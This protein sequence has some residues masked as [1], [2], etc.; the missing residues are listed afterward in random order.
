MSNTM[1]QPVAWALFAPN[2]NIR[3][4]SIN[5]EAVHKVAADEGW[6]LTPLYAAPPTADFEFSH[7]AMDDLCKRMIELGRQQVAEP[8]ASAW[9]ALAMGAAASIEDAANCLHDHDAR[10]QAEGAAKHYREAAHKLIGPSGVT[11]C[12][13][14]AVTRAIEVLEEALTYIG[15]PSW[16][17]SMLREAEEALAGL[18]E[19]VSGLAIPA[20]GPKCERCNDTGWHYSDPLDPT[21]LEPCCEPADRAGAA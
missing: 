3:M 2:G 18:R 8:A 10:K 13:S 20:P 17:P 19:H 4:W 7:A 5:S 16:S 15:S 1:P 14:T 6:P 12:A 11:P 9:W 21:S